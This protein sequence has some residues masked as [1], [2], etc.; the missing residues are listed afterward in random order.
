MEFFSGTENQQPFRQVQG[1]LPGR[2]KNSLRFLAVRMKADKFD[3]AMID[4]LMASIQ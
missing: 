1:Y 3:E 4:E 2:Q